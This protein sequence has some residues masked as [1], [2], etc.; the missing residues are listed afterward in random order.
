MK[1]SHLTFASSKDLAIK[2]RNSLENKE[3]IFDISSACDYLI[4]HQNSLRK[5]S[6]DE[7]VFSKIEH[8]W[9][10]KWQVSLDF[11]LSTPSK[12]SN[13]LKASTVLEQPE[14]DVDITLPDNK[15]K[16]FLSPVEAL[17][18][19][20]TYR[21]FQDCPLSQGVL[22]R[23][24]KELK[25]ELFSGI[26]KYYIVIFNIEGI[27]PGIYRYCPKRHGLLLTRLGLFRKEIVQ[28][29]CGMAASSTAAFLIILAVDLKIAMKNFPYDRALR[30]IYIDSGRLAQKLLIK[31]MQ[32]LIG[33]LPSPAMQD[34]QLCSFLEINPTDCIPI[35]NVT[36][37]LIPE[38]ISRFKVVK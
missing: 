7:N 17:L 37:G 13:T 24:L 30:E 1:L 36:M 15:D 6:V 34:T 26:W 16:D 2:I 8:W 18:Q 14:N 28:L 23:L 27:E 33:G 35:Y 9:A 20:K 10:R 19:R 32:N 31:G 4:D 25:E 5:N 12:E 38:S 21:K 22:S 29:L 11:Y 3:T